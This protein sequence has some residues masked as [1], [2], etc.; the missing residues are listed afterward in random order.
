M[1]IPAQLAVPSVTQSYSADGEPQTD[2]VQKNADRRVRELTWY[3]DALK[4]ARQD[5]T[6]S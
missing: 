3:V 6:P 2:R 4:K 5:G 1:S